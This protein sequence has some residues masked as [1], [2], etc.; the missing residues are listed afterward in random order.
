MVNFRI[1]DFLIQLKNASMARRKTIIVR[2]TKNVTA[3][4]L[5]LKSL[6]FLNEVN[7]VDGFLN[8]TLAYHKKQPVLINVKLI[9]TPGLRVY[10]GA[11]E[12]AARKRKS[13]VLLVSTPKG[14]MGDKEAVKANQGGE[15]YAEIT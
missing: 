10:V 6:G 12:L 2:A 1:G 15:I 9:S 3:T 5:V 13:S 14:V 8:V 4:A 7:E 11:K